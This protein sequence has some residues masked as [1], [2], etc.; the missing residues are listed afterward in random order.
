MFTCGTIDSD[1]IGLDFDIRGEELFDPE[2]GKKIGSIT[3]N[4]I[5]LVYRSGTLETPSAI[6]KSQG[7]FCLARAVPFEKHQGKKSDRKLRR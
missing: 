1:W 4:K 6:F 3:K 2:T 7:S 5:L